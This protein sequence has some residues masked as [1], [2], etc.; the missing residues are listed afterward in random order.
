MGAGARQAPGH[1]A[2]CRTG[3]ARS[4]PRGT[5]STSA[6]ATARCRRRC[7]PNSSRSRTCRRSRSTARADACRRPSAVELEPDAPLPFADGTFDLVVCTETIEHVHDLQLFLSEVRRVLEPRRTARPDDARQPLPDPPRR[8]RSRRTCAPHEA[9]PAGAARADGLRRPARCG[10]AAAGCSPWR[11]VRKGADARPDRHQLR[12]PRPVGHGGLHRAADRRAARARE[13]RGGRGAPPAPARAGA[14]PPAR[15]GALERAQRAAR[16]GVDAGLAA[17]AGPA[18]PRGRDPPPAARVDL[19]RALRP[20][21]H[22]PRPRVRASAGGLRPDLARAGAAPA[23]RGRAA[24]GR[25]DLRVAH[26]GR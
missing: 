14:Q 23:P 3:S 16:R 24:C 12:R 4:S 6:A 25:G 11:P 18:R 15:R 20:G 13:R 1:R 5:R 10:G 17:T 19:A 7:A 26:G 22:G 21:D 2:I 8:T 9:E